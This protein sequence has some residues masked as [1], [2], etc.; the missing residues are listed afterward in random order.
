MTRKD[1]IALAAEI[2]RFVGNAATMPAP[3]MVNDSRDL[4][5]QIATGRAIRNM[6]QIIADAL[7]A[8]NPRFDRVRFLAACGVAPAP[9]TSGAEG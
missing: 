3:T 8:D 7:A 2:R 5:C 9:V 4:A 1:Y 6:A